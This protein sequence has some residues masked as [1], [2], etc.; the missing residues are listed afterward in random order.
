VS[1]QIP[2]ALEWTLSPLNRTIP[3][4]IR[5]NLMILREDLLDEG[6][7]KPVA[8]NAAYKVG[9]AL[10]N[11]L[12]A[13]LDERDRALIRAGYTAAQANA[14][15]V[16]RS[17]ALEARRSRMDWPTYQR[18]KDQREEIRK[19]KE[20]SATLAKQRPAAEWS[21]RGIQLRKAVDDLYARFR[22]EIRQP[23]LTK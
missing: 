12:L 13:M 20:S 1:E 7:K 10:C 15:V 11:E 14:N 23:A 16:V 18:E 21:E 5:K 17:Q 2:N 22:E 19:E 3:P 6:A 4:E 8:S 9:Q